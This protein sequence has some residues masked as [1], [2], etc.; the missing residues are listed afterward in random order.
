MGVRW[1]DVCTHGAISFN[2]VYG[3][4]RMAS[5]NHSSWGNAAPE[6]IRSNPFPNLLYW[7][8]NE[9][10]GCTIL[11]HFTTELC[12]CV[13]GY[14]TVRGVKQSHYTGKSRIKILA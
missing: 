7:P 4:V 3:Q 1:D 12:V 8:Q 10:L 9:Q 5:N 2:Q 13:P 6:V 11:V 14:K